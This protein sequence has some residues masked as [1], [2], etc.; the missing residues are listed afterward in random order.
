MK[1]GFFSAEQVCQLARISDTQLRYWHQ[2]NVFRP[3][4]LADSLGPFRQAYA[5]RDVVGLRTVSILR[6]EH[7]VALKDIRAIEKN[8]KQTPDAGW[9]NITFHIGEDG[10]IYFEDL[11]SK[12][13]VSANHVGRTSLFRMRSVIESVEKQLDL[14][15]RRGKDQIGKVD[16]NRHIMGN[17]PVIAGTRIPTHAIFDL[18]QN[19]F[20]VAQIVAEYPRLT[21]RDVKAAI[22][23]EQLQVAS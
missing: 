19:G 15:N 14:M 16:R 6:N 21:E 13:A 4:R 2:T 5:F 1:L 7:N 20:S 11:K 9:S 22:Q 12:A 23:F 18:H 3:Q 8:L 10:R 17:A